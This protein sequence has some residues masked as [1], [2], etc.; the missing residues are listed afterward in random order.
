LVKAVKLRPQ[1]YK[2]F[3]NYHRIRLVILDN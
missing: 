2:E 1:K 3:F